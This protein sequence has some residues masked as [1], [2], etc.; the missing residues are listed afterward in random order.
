M[1]S[2][3]TK[4][5]D[6]IIYDDHKRKE[7]EQYFELEK[8]LENNNSFDLNEYCYKIKELLK[9]HYPSKSIQG[10]T[11]FHEL[12]DEFRDKLIYLAKKKSYDYNCYYLNKYAKI[13]LA[14]TFFCQGEKDYNNRNYESA[15][16]LFEQT[17]DLVEYYVN[18]NKRGILK[19]IQEKCHNSYQ[20][21][22]LYMAYNALGEKREY[23]LG[24]ARFYSEPGMNIEE[25]LYKCC[26]IPKLKENI[27][28]K[29]NNNRHLNNEL[30]SI[31]NNINN[32]K[33]MI[34]TKKKDN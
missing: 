8:N 15:S 11:D 25:L 22:Y 26:N 23:Y 13:K 29:E 3:L 20:Y 19:S 14:H 30:N 24:Y 33:I 27:N 6:L 1:F 31:N 5:K 9:K 2:F 32:I 12:L 28:Q 7:Y 4:L 18:Y 16:K 21:Y 10:Y 17:L 34:D